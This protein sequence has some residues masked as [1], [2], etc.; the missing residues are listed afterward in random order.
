[1]VVLFGLTVDICFNDAGHT[2]F[3][4]LGKV[5]SGIPSVQL[6][7]VQ[8]LYSVR[9][10]IEPAIIIS[11]IG[12]VESI[13]V[14]K[15]MA[16]KHQY[17]VSANRELFALGVANLGGSFFGTYPTFGS[18][19]RTAINDAAGAK[20]QFAGL[21]SAAVI[22]LCILVLGPIFYHL[23]K[24][25][26]AAIIVVAGVGLI[27][28]DEIMFL[29][30][31]R[32]WKDI[33]ILAFVWLSTFILGVELGIAFAFGISIFKVIQTSS[34]STL[35]VLGKIPGTTSYKDVNVFVDAEQYEGLLHVRFEGSLFFANI[36]LLRR[37]LESLEAIDYVLEDETS[38]EP[39]FAVI[40]DMS[41]VLEIDASAMAFLRDLIENYV[42]R[43][44]KVC[45]VKLSDRNKAMFRR[46]GL[47]G[48]VG[49]KNFFGKN[50]SA[51][52]S[53]IPCVEPV[54]TYAQ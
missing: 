16:A 22:L 37:L 21:L 39:I 34:V 9:R 5:A 23:P 1:M 45:F 41:R 44:V 33:L 19:S 3:P 38:P 29:Y 14:A 51:V 35:T 24:A 15:S 40:F 43:H 42:Q 12:F 2:K 47:V 32:A 25:T 31:I 48:K 50:H 36:S 49:E 54:T 46:C 7:N 8:S 30:R 17:S 13:V 20:S 10:L 18:I 27:E 52:L 11:V 4:V 53:I 26:M 28:V 6:P